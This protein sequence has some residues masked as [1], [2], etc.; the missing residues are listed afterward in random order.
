MRIPFVFTLEASFAG[1]N[2]GNLKGKHFS[3]GDLINV[4]KY[5]LK[6]IWEVKKLMLNKNLLKQ[7][8]AEAQ[9]KVKV[10]DDDNQDSD[11]G[12]SSEG[13]QELPTAKEKIQKVVEKIEEEVSPD[14]KNKE[15]TNPPE[16]NSEL[17]SPITSA[18]KDMSLVE[19]DSPAKI[20]I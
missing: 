14:L 20:S 2:Q 10:T 1:A 11:C 9:S 8:A 15:M 12:S 19:Q 6:A 13:E 17:Q 3:A 16:V 7:I 5:V 18:R 4:G